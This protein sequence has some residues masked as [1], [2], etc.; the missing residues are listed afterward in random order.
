MPWVP[1]HRQG[2]RHLL[3]GPGWGYTTA[4]QGLAQQRALTKQSARAIFNPPH[5]PPTL[6]ALPKNSNNP[7]LKGSLSFIPQ[8]GLVQSWPGVC[9]RWV[10][11]PER[12]PR[13]SPASL[14]P[15]RP[16][17]AGGERRHDRPHPPPLQLC[18]LCIPRPREQVSA[19]AGPPPGHGPGFCLVLLVGS[20]DLYLSALPHS[21]SRAHR[22]RDT[23]KGKWHLDWRVAYEMRT[24]RIQIM[25]PPL[26]NKGL[27]VVTASVPQSPLCK[28]DND[29]L[30]YLL[31]GCQGTERAQHMPGIWQGVN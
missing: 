5:S 19:A 6:A 15:Q 3:R 21:L 18:L 14:L 23:E 12:S 9:A 16:A 2:H 22:H 10:L 20:R 13:V 29:V 24:I 25:T 27:A 17:G 26:A 11:C 1:T 8:T 28:Q 31:K 4:P 7:Y 30:S